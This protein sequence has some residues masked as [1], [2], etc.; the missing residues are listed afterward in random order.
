MPTSHQDLTLNQTQT[1]ETRQYEGQG[2]PSNRISMSKP[3]SCR[4]PYPRTH[5]TWQNCPTPQANSQGEQLMLGLCVL[6]GDHLGGNGMGWRGSPALTHGSEAVK[7]WALIPMNGKDVTEKWAELLKMPVFVC[8]KTKGRIGRNI[9]QFMFSFPRT[10]ILPL[11]P[12]I[13]TANFVSG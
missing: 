2:N 1:A 6:L 4:Q 3:C 12:K 10:L 8:C 11:I 9:S 5:V 13:N 7:S